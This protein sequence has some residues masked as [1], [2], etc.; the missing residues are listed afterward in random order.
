MIVNEAANAIRNQ[1]EHTFIVASD[2]L[3]LAS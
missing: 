2:P 3:A 1:T